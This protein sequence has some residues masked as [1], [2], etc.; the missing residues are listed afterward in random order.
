MTRR[1]REPSSGP[2]RA[3]FGTLAGLLIAVVGIGALAGCGSGSP[4]ALDPHSPQARRIANLFW[5]MLVLAIVIYLLVVGMVLISLRTRGSDPDAHSDSPGPER[6][7]LSNRFIVIGGL[8]IPI[9]VLSVVAVATVSATKALEN[10]EGAIQIRVDAEQYWWRLIYEQDGVV[11]AN[12]IHVPVGK[13]VVLTLTSDNVIHSVWVPQL[14]GKVDVVPGQTN[15]MSF[16]AQQ[17]GTYRGQCAEFCGIG[18]ALMAFVVVVQS[19][20]DYQSWLA[21]NRATPA[22]PTDPNVVAGQRLLVEGSCAGCHVVAGTAA[23]GTFG[24]D[25][26]HFGSRG[27]IAALQLPNDPDHLARWLAHTQDVKPGALM[28]QIDLTQDDVDH[29]VAYLESLR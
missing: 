5:L 24:P 7:S 1:S 19:D 9:V 13:P 25:L 28:P 27:S 10:R 12:E 23:T 8:A 2:V 18:H 3:R 16:T 11:S 22:A 29:L 20:A 21:A 15:R 4:S 14:N 6:R 17:T 26:T